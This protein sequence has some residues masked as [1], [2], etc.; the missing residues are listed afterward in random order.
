MYHASRQPAALLRVMDHNFHHEGSFTHP[1]ALRQRMDPAVYGDAF[2]LHGLTHIDLT[3]FGRLGPRSPDV[4]V[5]HIKVRCLGG[6]SVDTFIPV[7]SHLPRLK[8]LDLS[9]I[10]VEKIDHL[11]AP[12]LANVAVSFTSYMGDF[13]AKN[14]PSAMRIAEFTNLTGVRLPIR[15][16]LLHVFPTCLTSLV[17]T[18]HNPRPMDKAQWTALHRYSR[19]TQ[20]WILRPFFGKT[21]D[22]ACTTSVLPLVLSGLKGVTDCRFNYPMVTPECKDPPMPDEFKDDPFLDEEAVNLPPAS[23]RV[24]ESLVLANQRSEAV[25]S[26][27]NWLRNRAPNLRKLQ[28][29]DYLDTIAPFIPTTVTTLTY[30]GSMKLP[31]PL[32]WLRNLV[33]RE[34]AQRDKLRLSTLTL[35]SELT[36]LRSEIMAEDVPKT[37][38]ASHWPKLQKL[39]MSKF[40][41]PNFS[42]KQIATLTTLRELSLRPYSSAADWED[43]HQLSEL[44]SLDI[45]A[46][47]HE[48]PLTFLTDVVCRLPKLVHLNLGTRTELKLVDLDRLP[49]LAQPALQSLVLPWALRTDARVESL[50]RRFRIRWLQGIKSDDLGDDPWA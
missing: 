49:E 18:V 44:T 23:L 31:V 30:C 25:I 41:H 16:D 35:L 24:L 14:E 43:L 36:S 47:C 3:N 26:I 13:K 8:T 37:P 6:V 1:E 48:R 19:L 40:V 5:P 17:V 2:K 28:V 10:D 7:L 32:P 46:W 22:T 4:A 50:G 12:H 38:M 21:R 9:D 42:K 15:G 20:L 39:F 27:L 45:S 11:R 33:T 29:F 34:H